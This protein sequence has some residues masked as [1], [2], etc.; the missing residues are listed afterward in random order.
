MIHL[1]NLHIFRMYCIITVS[2]LTVKGSYCWMSCT[3]EANYSHSP[4]C[5]NPDTYF[6]LANGEVQNSWYTPTSR[7]RSVWRPTDP[8]VWGPS[9]MSSFP[10]PGPVDILFFSLDLQGPSHL[11]SY[12]EAAEFTV[13]SHLCVSFGLHPCRLTVR[14]DLLLPQQQRVFRAHILF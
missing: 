3:I 11:H 12:R 13:P 4:H 9:A 8:V 7:S 5:K 14:P 2:I 10:R 6:S 1:Q